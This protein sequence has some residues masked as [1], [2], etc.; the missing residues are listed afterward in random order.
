MSYIR[1]FAILTIAVISAALAFL[2]VRILTGNFKLSEI[3]FI[4]TAS[5]AASASDCASAG[6]S[7]KEAA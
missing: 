6:S 7:L 5:L 1:P 3:S 2:E 4:T